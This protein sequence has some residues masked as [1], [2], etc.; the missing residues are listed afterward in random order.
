M[1]FEGD[2]VPQHILDFNSMIDHDP[3]MIYDSQGR[4]LRWSYK[5]PIE[6]DNVTSRCCWQ[7]Q[8]KFEEVEH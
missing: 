6:F 1:N 7:K 5:A 8:I 3:S 2:S 4:L